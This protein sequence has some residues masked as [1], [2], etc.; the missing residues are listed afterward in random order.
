MQTNHELSF[1]KRSSLEENERFQILPEYLKR[2]IPLIQNATEEEISEIIEDPFQLLY[3]IS[4]YHFPQ[5][6]NEDFTLYGETI[7]PY[8]N[9][10][11]HKQLEL[12]APEYPGDKLLLMGCGGLRP[13]C[14]K[15]VVT[16]N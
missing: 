2:F 9:D 12:N 13:P 11:G 6:E 10:P 5:N 1:F 14:V 16:L 8:G 7:P 4:K 3:V 15:L